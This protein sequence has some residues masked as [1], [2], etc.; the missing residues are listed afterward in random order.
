MQEPNNFV[1]SSED[2]RE[3]KGNER[4]LP[5]SIAEKSA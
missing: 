5:E 2:G 3:K 1:R 4:K